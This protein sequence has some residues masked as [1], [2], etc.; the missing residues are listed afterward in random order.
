MSTLNQLKVFIYWGQGLDKMPLFL[1]TI[2]KHNL[3]ICKKNNINLILIDDK[4]VYNYITPHSKFKNLRYNHKSDVIRYYILH[5]YGGFWLDVDVIIIKN[6]NKLIKNNECILD[7]E[8]GDKIGCA[9]LFI[10]KNS[11]VSKFCIDYI[12]N[13]LN[14]KILYLKW[15]EIGPNTVEALYK[16]HSS[17]IKLNKYNVVKN[18]C[19][20]ICWN[21]VP[22]LYKNKWLF[23]NEEQ[24]KLKAEMLKNNEE[25]YYLITW[26]MYR[27]NNMGYKINDIVFNDKRSVFSYFVNYEK[28][29]FIFRLF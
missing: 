27:K 28:P 6:L 13:I 5:K 12:D 9:S 8:F 7:V 23:F 16:K 29:R 2:Y 1:K 17:I 18:G 21:D 20:F 22:G 11:I 24:A 19:N 3:E 10:K 25:C 4:N 26:T 14:K 15:D